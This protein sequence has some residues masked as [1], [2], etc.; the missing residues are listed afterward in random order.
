MGNALRCVK[1]E[2]ILARE[3]SCEGV[4]GSAALGAELE[5]GRVSEAAGRAGHLELASAFHAELG[6]FRILKL[7]L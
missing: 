6:S 4:H 3:N 7:A 2:V 5:A 1:E